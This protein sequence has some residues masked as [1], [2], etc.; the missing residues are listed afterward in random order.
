MQVN[1]LDM[2]KEPYKSAF[3]FVNQFLMDECELAMVVKFNTPFYYYKT[4]W[5]GF[6]SYNPK[7]HEIYIS[8]VKG[9]KVD[10][11]KLL[12]EGRKQQKIYRI[13]PSKDINVV[14]LQKIINLLKNHY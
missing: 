9:H 7:T 13:D 5:F 2:L 11:E 8:F 6:L 3:I 1:F 4:K 14:E 12:S 10:H